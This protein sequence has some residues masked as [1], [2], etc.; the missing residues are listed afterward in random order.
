[1]ERVR[2]VVFGCLVV[3]G[4]WLCPLPAYAADGFIGGLEDL[5]GTRDVEQVSYED[6][7]QEGYEPD[8][9]EPVSVTRRE[10]DEDATTVDYINDT[11]DSFNSVTWPSSSQSLLVSIQTLFTRFRENVFLFAAG[12]VFMWWGVRKTVR[13]IMSA[14]RKGS[15]SV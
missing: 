6:R 5:T 11:V 2:V 9:T 4:V 14:F 7:Y 10:L 3:L 13:M 8:L 12:I 15:A 1:M